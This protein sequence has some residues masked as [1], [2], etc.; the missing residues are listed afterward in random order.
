MDYEILS[1]KAKTKHEENM[2]IIKLLDKGQNLPSVG[3]GSP[4]RGEKDKDSQAPSI[5]SMIHAY[6]HIWLEKKM[7]VT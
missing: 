7:R 2:Y 4:T 1:L 6:I 3:L 5:F